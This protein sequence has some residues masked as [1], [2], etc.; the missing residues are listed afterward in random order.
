MATGHLNINFNSLRTLLA[1]VDTGSHTGAAKRLG[2]TTSAVSQLM[3]A[4][5]KALGVDLFE[6]G[7]RSLLATPAAVAMS[8]HAQ[9]IL[10]QAARAE[11]EMRAFASGTVGSLRIG[12]AGSPAAQLVPRTLSRLSMK[13]AAANVS[14]TDFHRQAP[15]SSAV[16]EGKID[17][18]L[19]AQFG[20]LA[21]QLPEGLELVPLLQEELVVISAADTLHTPGATVPLASLKDET[22]IANSVGSNADELLTDLCQEAGFQPRSGLRSD[23]YDVIRNMVKETLGIALV[24]ALSLGIDRGISFNRLDPAPQRIIYAVH[25]SSDTNP[26]LTVAL[27]AL[28]IAVDD[29]IDWTSSAFATGLS[30]PLARAI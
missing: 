22:W 5:E 18:A 1:V 21:P 14:M 20:T 6:R 13:Y 30:T 17:V 8:R 27:D 9:I 26:L 28:R 2:Y 7:P 3:A 11:D 10:Q 15:L 24:P 16:L 19:H 23:D 4:L 25:R 29:F 12:A